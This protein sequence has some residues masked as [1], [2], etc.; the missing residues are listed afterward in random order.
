MT[1]IGNSMIEGTA[2]SRP[3]L[4]TDSH[5]TSLENDQTHSIAMTNEFV[6]GNELSPIWTD[7]SQNCDDERYVSTDEYY[8]EDSGDS[9]DNT[10]L[11]YEEANFVCASRS[12]DSILQI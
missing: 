11:T 2:D 3:M 5:K 10:D 6:V 7:R 1:N 4:L 8:S 12:V 9:S